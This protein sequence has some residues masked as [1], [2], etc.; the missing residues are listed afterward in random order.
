MTLL[1]P[2][3]LRSQRSLSRQLSLAAAV[4]RGE[5]SVSEMREIVADAHALVHDRAGFVVDAEA[6]QAADDFLSAAEALALPD[7]AR[8]PDNGWRP[9][10]E[11]VPA[12]RSVEDQSTAGFEHLISGGPS[13]GRRGRADRFSLG[14]NRS[15]RVTVAGR[16][17]GKAVR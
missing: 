2:T 4:R 6:T 5:M 11:G 16:S 3:G 7:A 9:S 17:R 10:G 13:A 15:R 14:V 1:T 8:M 12:D